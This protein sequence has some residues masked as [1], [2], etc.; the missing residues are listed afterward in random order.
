MP[1]ALAWPGQAS[2]DEGP[3][4][5]PLPTAEDN[6]NSYFV[7]A[8]VK[9]NSSYAFTL[10][11]LRGKRSCHP[12]FRSPAGWDVPVGALVQRGFIRPKDCDVL[13]G[14]TLCG[15]TDVQTLFWGSAGSEGLGALPPAGSHRA[16]QR[17]FLFLPDVP[18]SLGKVG[19]YSWLHL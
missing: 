14:T 12:A 6:S 16:A 19:K 4:W 15:D 5:R 11:E 8:V 1:R 3:H 9:R 13:T 10:D 2:T 18:H 7:V 17:G